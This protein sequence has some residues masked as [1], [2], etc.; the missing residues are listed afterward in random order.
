MEKSR[1]LG[2]CT[3][4]EGRWYREGSDGSGSEESLLPEVCILFGTFHL[5]SSYCITL[6]FH[7]KFRRRPRCPE[8]LVPKG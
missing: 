5:K 8:R 3:G 2:V 1:L 6:V 7:N 4:S